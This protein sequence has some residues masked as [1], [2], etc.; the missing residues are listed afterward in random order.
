MICAFIQALLMLFRDGSVLILAGSTPL[1]A[2]GSFT[3]A[4]N[5]WMPKLM[6]WQL[7]LI[8]YKPMA[9]MVYAAAIW[10]QGENTLQRPAGAARAASP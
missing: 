7:A 8:F 3:N 1:A 5:G 9:A 10:M 2:S 6:T 4:T